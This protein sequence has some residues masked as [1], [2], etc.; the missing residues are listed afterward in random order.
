MKWGGVKIEL[1]VMNASGRAE[2]SGRHRGQNG[3]HGG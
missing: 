1:E 2:Q 3:M